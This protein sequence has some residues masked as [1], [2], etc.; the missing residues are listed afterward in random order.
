MERSYRIASI[1]VAA[2]AIATGQPALAQY[3]EKPVR[4]VVPFPAGGATDLMARS[5]AQRLGE[6]LG[7]P[8]VVDN[9]GGAGGTIAAEAVASAPPDGYTLFFATMGT[10]VINPSLCSK[11]RYDPVKDFA[12]IVLAPA[13]TPKEIAARLNA[14]IAKVMTDPDMEKQLASQGIEPMSSTPET[15]AA[16]IKTDM[17]KWGKV[18]KASGASID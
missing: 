14:E 2:A 15:F 6:R 7:K 5:L 10:L 18:V 13:A 9:R 1:L 12:P 17:A 3:P 4:L 8:I 11:L 16:T